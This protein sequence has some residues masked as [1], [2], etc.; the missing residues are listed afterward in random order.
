VSYFLWKELTDL[1]NMWQVHKLNFHE[2]FLVT[3]PEEMNR[4]QMEM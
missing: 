4:L 3:G 2:T 1:C